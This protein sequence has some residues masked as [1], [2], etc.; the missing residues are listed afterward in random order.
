MNDITTT[1]VTTELAHPATLGRTTTGCTDFASLE[2]F[3]WIDDIS[4]TSKILR[5]RMQLA[6]KIG[7]QT[8][9]GFTLLFTTTRIINLRPNGVSPQNNIIRIGPHGGGPARLARPGSPSDF[10]L[11]AG[12]RQR[13]E[14]RAEPEGCRGECTRG[15]GPAGEKSGGTRRRSRRRGTAGAGP[16]PGSEALDVTATPGPAR[17]G[18]RCGNCHFAEFFAIRSVAFLRLQRTAIAT[19]VTVTVLR[20]CT[21]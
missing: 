3:V 7:V 18:G 6:L 11:A 9:A 15:T 8:P 14:Q 21:R 20:L 19:A 5:V 2:L 17:V 13:A 10:K 12:R 1:L 16:G 4:D